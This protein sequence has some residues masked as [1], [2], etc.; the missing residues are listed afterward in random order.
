MVN[1]DLQTVHLGIS[2]ARIY[3]TMQLSV[4]LVVV[5]LGTVGY[6]QFLS[7]VTGVETQNV[8]PDSMTNVQL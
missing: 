2:I 8:Q 7:C 1:E 5:L 6:S 3:N 4:C